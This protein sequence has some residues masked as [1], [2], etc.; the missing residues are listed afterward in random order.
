MGIHE[1]DKD[2]R[3]DNEFISGELSLLVEGN[4]CRLLDGRRTAGIIEKYSSESAMFRWRITKYEDKGKH[5]DLPAEHIVKFQFE[6]DS[7]RLDNDDVE[8]IK[9]RINELNEELSIIPRE[10][11]RIKSEKEIEQVKENVIKWLHKNSLFF[12]NKEVIDFSKHKGSQSLAKDLCNYMKSVDL[13]IEEKITSETLVLNPNSGEWIKGM[14]IVFAEMGLAS[15]K[16]SIPRTKDIFTERGSKENRRKY[17]INR[18]AFLRAYFT[19]CNIK[20]VV[21][22]RGMSTELGWT[23]VERTYL[24]CTLSLDVAKEFSDFSRE[25][26]YK[27]SY[28]VKLSCPIEK[29]FM[30]Y[31]ETEAMNRQ[32]KEAE[33]IILYDGAI[34]V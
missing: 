34:R 25:S 1:C 27:N 24:S 9:L 22:Y 8:A 20:E 7:C 28:L 26:R 19:M 33:A 11:D 15:Y 23:K 31:L 5:W 10:E 21:I 32:Y 12:R 6:K 16:D 13:E 30:T 18:L 17:L 4:R 3:L 14:S 2:I 29:I